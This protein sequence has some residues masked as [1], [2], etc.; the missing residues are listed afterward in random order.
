M[1]MGPD[2]L[3]HAT[4]AHEATLTGAEAQAPAYEVPHEV[5]QHVMPALPDADPERGW[6]F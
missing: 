5:A 1:T 2:N 3:L 4:L 6:E